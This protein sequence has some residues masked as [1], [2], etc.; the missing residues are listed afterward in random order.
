MSEG[1][2]IGSTVGRWT[3][4]SE[5]RK[6]GRK[7]YMCQ[8]ECGTVKEIYYRSL[9]T[10][11]SQ[12]CG[13]LRKELQKENAMDLT[14]ERFGR[15]VV[16]R[17]NPEKVDHWI[18]RCDCGRD[19]SI[20]G[21]SLRKEDGTRSCGCIQAEFA[22]GQGARSVRENTRKQ[23]EA[24]KALRTNLQVIKTK[25]PPKNNTSGV[26]GLSWDKAREQW[27]A[28]IQ[29]QGKRVSLGRYDKKEDAVKARLVAEEKYFAPLLERA[30]DEFDYE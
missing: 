6:S 22:V 10:G 24:D 17:R 2:H 29:V 20:R 30:K 28:Y 7:Y 27:S 23:I 12:S 25:Q 14:G 26:K 1:V 13:C 5:T 3:V 19:K 9:E 11:V 18:C 21:T 4:L 8:C 15:L 16:L